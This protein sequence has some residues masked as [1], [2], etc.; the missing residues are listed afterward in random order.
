MSARPTDLFDLDSL[1]TDEERAVRDTVRRFVDEKVMARVPGAYRDGVFPYELIKDF[2][3][4]GLLGATL[5]GYGC[6]GMGPYAYG[7]ALQELERADSGVRSFVSV[8][9]SL[10][11]FPIWKYG[12]DDQKT[13]LL[14]AVQQGRLVGCFGLTEPD[15]GSDPAAM[16]TR[17]QPDGD[18]F[19][20]T[21]T[22]RW[23]TNGTRAD[24]AVV[25]A[26]TGDDA[27]SIRGFIVEKGAKGFAQHAIEK[28]QSFRAS[29]TAEL[30][31][32]DVKLGKDA[33]LPGTKGLGSALGCLFE[34]RAGIAVG[35]LGSARDC[36]ETTIEFA[37]HRIAFGRPIAGMQLVQAKL[38]NMAGELAKAQLVAWRLCRLKEQGVVEP[39]QVSLAK[40]NNVKT[41]LDIARTCRDVLGANGI[42]D[43]YPVMRHMCNLETVFTYEGTHDIHALV[44]G[45]FLTGMQA[46]RG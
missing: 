42:T 46:F 38:A 26:R 10:C 33:L 29:D 12:S 32:E 30:V 35:V 25:W 43:E 5:T 39:V 37:K 28:K 14:P 17:A 13:R 18:G 21:G 9:G 1:L 41:A 3:A 11:M 34:A 44:V 20:L 45:N 16:R 24:V 27:S 19:V 23:I 7:L 22:K 6:A 2:A 8:Q 4:L 31:F 40:M 15:A 36:L